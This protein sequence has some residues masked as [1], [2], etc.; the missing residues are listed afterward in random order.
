M[1][2]CVCVCVCVCAYPI[3]VV[4]KIHVPLS[5]QRPANLLQQTLSFLCTHKLW[6]DHHISGVPRGRLTVLQQRGISGQGRHGGNERDETRPLSLELTRRT[7]C[8]YGR[9][10]YPSLAARVELCRCLTLHPNSSQQ[11]PRK[12]RCRPIVCRPLTS[13][14]R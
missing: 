14:G 10:L 7:K 13:R 6:N 4:V 9:A 3:P 11:R 2:V 12:R 8:E 5:S 1:C